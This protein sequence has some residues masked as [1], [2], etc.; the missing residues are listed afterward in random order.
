[1]GVA[2]VRGDNERPRVS[3]SRRVPRLLQGLATA[4]HQHDRVSLMQQGQRGR[5]PDPGPRAGDHCDLLLRLH[6][7]A[8]F[9]VRESPG[10]TAW[11]ADPLAG[12]RMARLTRWTAGFARGETLIRDDPT[13]E[14][15]TPHP[16]RAGFL[17]GRGYDRLAFAAS[18]MR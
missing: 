14:I 16:I 11:R 5:P 1:L 3:R 2:D 12:S 9:R 4:A 13:I 7:A 10:A 6:R 15:A 17:P 8:A 18:F